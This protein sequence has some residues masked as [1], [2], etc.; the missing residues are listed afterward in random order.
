MQVLIVREAGEFGR[1]LAERGIRFVER[2]AIRTVPAPGAAGLCG[3]LSGYDGV[4][5]TS[6]SA[7][8]V[9]AD[10]RGFA[11]RVF[12]LGRS[13]FEAL[14]GLGFD[15]CYFPE[16]NT[17][18]ELVA[19]IPPSELRGRRF[20][21]IRGDRSLGT[22]PE[23][24]GAVATVD[25]LI[26]Y[27]NE[28][29]AFGAAE[30]AALRTRLAAGEFAAVCFFSPSGAESFV[31]QIGAQALSATAVAAIGPTTAR[32]LADSGIEVRFVPRHSTASGFAAELADFLLGAAGKKEIQ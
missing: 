5:L 10:C 23:T 11:G 16:S 20:L 32:A 27:R 24:V 13:S 22:I 15:L 21:F 30:V 28:E 31:G 12:V 3:R 17:A 6:R 18:G 29:A 1:V 19:S 26:V 9:F 14:S 4:F 25:E 2:P 7:A 8:M